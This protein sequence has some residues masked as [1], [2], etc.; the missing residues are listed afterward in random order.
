MNNLG[1]TV[2]V[3]ALCVAV[4][5]CVIDTVQFSDAPNYNP[6]FNGVAYT[7]GYTGFTMGN[8]G[9]GDYDSGLFGPAQWSPRY[10]FNEGGLHGYTKYPSPQ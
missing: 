6:T 4:C 3:T 10:I 7:P 5:G 2:S 8:D 9:Y 1:Y